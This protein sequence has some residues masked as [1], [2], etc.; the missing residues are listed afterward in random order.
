AVI[1]WFEWWNAVW[2]LDVEIA[3]VTGAL[4]A[5]NVAGPRARE[6]MTRL[7]ELDVSNDGFAYLDAKEAHV[8]GVPSLILRIGFVGELGYEIHFPSPYG[9][10]LWDTILERGQDLGI[11]PFG[12]EPQRILRLEK[13]HILIGQDTD[14][15]S[16]ALE[17][18][19]PWIVK[20]DKDDFVGKWSLEQVQE[21]GFREQLVG[22]EM[23]NGVVPPEGGQIVVDGRPGGRVTSSRWS[24][25]L[26]KAIGM[27]WVP[28]ELAEEGAEIALK[29]NGS[30]ERARVRLRPFFDPDGENLRS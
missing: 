7:T 17:A 29:V 16:N 25:E 8:A 20:W 2:G 18:S 21:R 13:M 23:R 30:I 4:A 1:E 3:N 6:L 28:P 5:V 22:F 19:M 12:L 26:G 10:S 14:S 9:E 27:A 15:E 11:R 24:D